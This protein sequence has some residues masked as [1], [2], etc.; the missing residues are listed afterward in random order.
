M[1]ALEARGRSTQAPSIAALFF[2]LRRATVLTTLILQRAY[3]IGFG[4]IQQL[5]QIIGGLKVTPPF[6]PPQKAAQDKAVQL[7]RLRRANLHPTPRS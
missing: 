4:A 6:S 5:L 1:A 3:G 7:T 2:Q